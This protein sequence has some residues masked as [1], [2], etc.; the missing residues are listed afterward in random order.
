[1][2][3]H[4]YKNIILVC[5]CFIIIGIIG[6]ISN[7]KINQFQHRK[8]INEFIENTNFRNGDLIF[9]KGKSL[10]SQAVLVSDNN[11]N[12]SHVGMIRIIDNKTFV[13]HAV[14]GESKTGIDYI[15]CEP[16][17]EFLSFKKASNGAVYRLSDS[18]INYDKAS[19][20]AYRCF[21]SKMLFDDRY[22]YIS[23][24]KYYCTELVWKAYKSCGIDILNNKIG[25]L[26]LPFSK[27]GIIL[28]SSLI[29]SKYVDI[30]SEF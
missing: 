2:R 29:K 11:S 30:I 28:P 25:I 27:K 12:Y 26:N 21:T 7:I 23:E 15:K 19:L 22:D 6:F 1:M 9:R 10:A 16:V 3:T 18:G 8:K 24:N 17:E 13:I 14:P 20:I 4:N 5:F